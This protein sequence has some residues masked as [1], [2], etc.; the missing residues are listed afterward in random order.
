[1][2][3]K[4]PAVADVK[5]KLSSDQGYRSL[6]CDKLVVV[7][8]PVLQYPDIYAGCLI[9]I[10]IFSIP[11]SIQF[12]CCKNHTAIPVENFEQVVFGGAFCY[13]FKII[14]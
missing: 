4:V 12:S 11:S 7:R 8:V 5:N 6:F 1:M 14:I 2:S 13:G 9:G 3:G 10:L